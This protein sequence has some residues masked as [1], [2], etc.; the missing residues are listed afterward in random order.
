MSTTTTA[1]NNTEEKKLIGFF[2]QEDSALE[3]AFTT[4]EIRTLIDE[5]PS[6]EFSKLTD[7][8]YFVKK[9]PQFI[10]CNAILSKN[11]SKNTGRIFY[12]CDLYISNPYHHVM[13]T[14]DENTYMQIML[15]NDFDMKASQTMVPCRV[16]FLKGYSEQALSEDHSFYAI[17]AI[18]PSSER[19][20]FIR[21]FI[22]GGERSYL[23]SLSKKNYQECLAKGIDCFA[24]RGIQLYLLKDDKVVR[25]LWANYSGDED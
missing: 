8:G 4:K 11:I 19:K 23:N 6:E 9:V 1:T 20:I 22:N 24:D 12:S 15:D 2:D 18:F 14:F 7:K 25:N 5:I 16:R 21:D 13:S 17:E 3:K 10:G